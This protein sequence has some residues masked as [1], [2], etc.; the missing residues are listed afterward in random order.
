MSRFRVGRTAGLAAT[1]ALIAVGAAVSAASAADAFRL[2]GLGGGELTSAEVER[3]TTVVVVWAAW[4]PRCRDIVE[5]VNSLESSVGGS[6][7][8]VTVD[9]QEEP[10][11]IEEFL[12]GKAL[13]AP[14]YLDRDGEFS[15][16]ME[17][18]SLPGL[19][20]FR[21]GAVRYK[22]R[23]TADPAATVAEAVR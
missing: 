23:L 21:D 22:G 7:R 13:R 19:V 1:L 2:A 12:K 16:S 17:V 5:R 11:A 14:V 9:F 8:V 4:S 10:A 3:G 15:K 20:V 18:T 6:A